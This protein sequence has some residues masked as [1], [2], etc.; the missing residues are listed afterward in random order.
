MFPSKHHCIPS[1]CQQFWSLCSAMRV[2]I[3]ILA[4]EPRGS[5]MVGLVLGL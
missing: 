5:W 4:L 2:F 3:L 1:I